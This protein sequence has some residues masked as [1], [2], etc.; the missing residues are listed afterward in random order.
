MI[1]PLVRAIGVVIL[2]IW[3]TNPAHASV[4][5][6]QTL[7]S[8]PA[9]LD[10]ALQEGVDQFYQIRESILS[11]VRKADPERSWYHMRHMDEAFISTYLSSVT[12]SWLAFED[13][14]APRELRRLFMTA[15]KENTINLNWLSNQFY[16]ASTNHS[17]GMTFVE[18][19][20]VSIEILDRS[21]IQVPLIHELTHLF[22]EDLRDARLNMDV[23]YADLELTLQRPTEKWSTEERE[24]FGR[25]WFLRDTYLSYYKELKP[26]INA[27]IL[28]TGL[29]MLG[30][31]TS[32]PKQ[33]L[34]RY[35][36]VI[37][38]K[39]SCFSL[40]LN[41]IKSVAGEPQFFWSA[42]S[43]EGEIERKFH[44]NW[45]IKVMQENPEH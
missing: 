32:L 18:N 9:Q 33:D 28:F 34:K 8:A 7:Q 22:D 15:L 30:E 2:V 35:K 27:C 19:Q 26:R 24:K 4:Q 3:T 37:D 41:E 43:P 25:Y 39:I 11:S 6:E 1:Q 38:G 12:E 45:L 40:S 14:T 29:Y 42:D 20:R 16:G 44:E 17:R 10:R 36:P 23:L 31:L 13:G 21:A 5:L